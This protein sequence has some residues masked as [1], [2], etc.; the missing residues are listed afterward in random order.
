MRGQHE[1]IIDTASN[2]AS[3]MTRQGREKN[4]QTKFRCVVPAEYFHSV[5]NDVLSRLG[6]PET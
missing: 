1:G 4:K 5:M 6:D 3:S 2:K